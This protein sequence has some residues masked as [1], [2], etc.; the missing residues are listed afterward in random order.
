MNA[1]FVMPPQVVALPDYAPLA[2]IFSASLATLA[3]LLLNGV[4]SVTTNAPDDIDGAKAATTLLSAAA[5]APHV[6]ASASAAAAALA[7]PISQLPIT[8]RRDLIALRSRLRMLVG[9]NVIGGV[10][11]Q[12]PAV[13][14]PGTTETAKAIAAAQTLVRDHVLHCLL[15]V[16]H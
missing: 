16:Q 13:E 4:L 6:S 15:Y 9:S 10:S 12:E 14:A 11:S 7:L 8:P 5:G 2:G 3:Q 1:R